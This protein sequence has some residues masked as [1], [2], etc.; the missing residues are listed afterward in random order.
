VGR[1]TRPFLS[2]DEVKLRAYVCSIIDR[3]LGP[4]QLTFAQS[5]ERR[6]AVRLYH[7]LPREGRIWEEQGS[8]NGRQEHEEMR[9]SRRA[10]RVA[11]KGQPEDS[12]TALNKLKA[13]TREREGTRPGGV[14]LGLTASK[15][16]LHSQLNPGTL[17]Q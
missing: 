13:A 17:R 6:T 2:G 10:Q 4:F 12:R 15:L 3:I 16:R 11:E 14:P 9:S 7:N 1:R 8:V 5:E